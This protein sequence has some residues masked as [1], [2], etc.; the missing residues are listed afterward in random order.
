MYSQAKRIDSSFHIYL[1]FNQKN[2]SV[3]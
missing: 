3:C 1:F 2:E